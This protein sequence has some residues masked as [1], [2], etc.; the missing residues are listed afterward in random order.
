MFLLQELLVTVA[1][2]GYRF[3]TVTPVT[4]QHFL[5]RAGA[6]KNTR[7]IFGWNLRFKKNLLSPYLFDLMSQANL[8]VHSDGYCRSK[9]R[10][11]SLDHDLF[12]HSSFPTDDKQA[13]FFGPDTYRFA[14]FIQQSLKVLQLE[15]GLGVQNTLRILDVGCGSGAGGVA[16]ARA[17]A[18]QI[19]Y[20]LTL[21]DL[22]PVAL[23]YATACSRVAAVPVTILPGDFFNIHNVT[24]DLII[25]NP[26]YILDPTKRLYR[27]GGSQFGLELSVRIVKHA[28]DLLAPGG[29]LLLYTGVAMASDEKNPLLAELMP[30]FSSGNFCW[31]FEEID[32]DIFSEE[33]AQPAYDGIHRIA[34]VGL[35]IVRIS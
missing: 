17:L 31:S 27:D 8:L 26:P 1:L 32:P 18:N 28:L 23:A 29:R 24:F 12:L 7:D 30:H 15:Q 6:A 14:R 9:I 19:N 11:S 25:S 34:A 21:N 10:I 13:V 20:V 3:T 33:L 4:H 16:A 22:N 2:Q 35:T 5:S